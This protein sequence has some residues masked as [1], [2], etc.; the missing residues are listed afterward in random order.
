MNTVPTAVGITGIDSSTRVLADGNSDVAIPGDIT[1]TNAKSFRERFPVIEEPAPFLRCRYTGVIYPNQFPFNERSD[2]VEA[3]W[4][5][6]VV[7]SPVPV[8]VEQMVAAVAAPV[9][10]APKKG[11]T[12]RVRTAD[13]IEVTPVATTENDGITHSDSDDLTNVPL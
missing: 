9:P 6:P 3:Y 10:A 13:A 11:K 7:A 4:G 1:G 5:E 8:Q 12:K 2:M